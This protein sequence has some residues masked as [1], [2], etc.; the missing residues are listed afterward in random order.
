MEEKQ[1]ERRRKR[2]N[3]IRKKIKD[4]NSENE[5]VLG[6]KKKQR[7]GGDSEGRE[8][9]RKNECVLVVLS[10]CGCGKEGRKEGSLARADKRREP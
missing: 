2:R 7:A 10:D 9:G 3:N 1:V 6:L 4:K 5:K 8:G